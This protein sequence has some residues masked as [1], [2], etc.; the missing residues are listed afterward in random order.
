M[1]RTSIYITSYPLK[2]KVVS[3]KPKASGIQ[4]FLSGKFLIHPENL[5]CFF[6]HLLLLSFILIILS[7]NSKFK[8]PLLAQKIVGVVYKFLHGL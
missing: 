8:A 2:E 4:L 7:I 1:A 3:L 6:Y 5:L